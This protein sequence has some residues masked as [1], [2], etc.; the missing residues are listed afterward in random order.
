M[1]S[2]HSFVKLTAN[3]FMKV[4]IDTKE[5]FHV[6]CP[7]LSELTANMADVLKQTYTELVTKGP[8]NVVFDLEQVDSIDEAVASAIGEMAA[9]A[10]SEKSSFVICNLQPPVKK[11]LES[12][13]L[14]EHINHT[15]TQSE[16]WDI[17]QMEEIER[18][19]DL[20]I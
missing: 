2:L 13:G 6:I 16:A 15:P 9:T 8:K 10:Q 17:V 18:E 3:A 11:T 20:D 19:L 4:K 1:V 5:I 7:E 12:A 14:L